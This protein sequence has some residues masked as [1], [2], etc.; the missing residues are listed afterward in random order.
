MSES[1]TIDEHHATETAPA[2]K[3]QYDT[4]L[5]VL[6]ELDPMTVVDCEPVAGGCYLAEPIVMSGE[7]RETCPVCKTAH[8]KMVLRQKRVK[9]AHMFCEQCTRCFDACYPDGTSA[10]SIA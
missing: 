6:I 5:F 8:L 2:D 4:N 1:E 10:L 3:R 9:Q 7:M